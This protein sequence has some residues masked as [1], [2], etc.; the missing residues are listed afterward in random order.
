MRWKHSFNPI[1]DLRATHPD[2][3]AYPVGDERHPCRPPEAVD[4]LHSGG[5]RHQDH[6]FRVTQVRSRSVV[7]FHQQF[8]AHRVV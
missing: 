5:P 8:V 6:F 7:L 4:F 3:K 2:P 1:Q